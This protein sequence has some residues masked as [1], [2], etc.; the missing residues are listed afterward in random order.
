MS[1]LDYL[2][3]ISQVFGCIAGGGRAT[4]QVG[5]LSLEGMRIKWIS[6]RPR[7]CAPRLNCPL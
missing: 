1:E 4:Y 7:I 5:A 2:G 6:C 3:I